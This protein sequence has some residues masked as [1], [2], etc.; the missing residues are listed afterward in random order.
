MLHLLNHIQAIRRDVYDSIQVTM[1]EISPR[2][3]EYQRQTLA[4]HA[5]KCAFL[6]CSAQDM[7]QYYSQPRGHREVFVLMME[8]L[9]NMVHDKVSWNDAGEMQQA[10]VEMNGDQMR[11][12]YQPLQDK[13]IRFFPENQLL[14]PTKPSGALSR[15]VDKYLRRTR[16]NAA[17]VPTGAYLTFRALSECVPNHRLIACDFDYLPQGSRVKGSLPADGTLD[18]YNAPLVSGESN[19]A[20]HKGEAVD[21]FT[22]LVPL[23]S[24]DIF[25]PTYFPMLKRMY[26]QV[27]KRELSK[28]EVIKSRE[29][30]AAHAPVKRAATRSGY[31]PL[32]E[33]FANTSFLLC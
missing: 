24:S 2:L 3:A 13:H 14:V 4:K 32:L 6:Q 12:V 8:V 30:L 10:S 31:N 1:V 17:F 33:D 20:N 29:F 5:D 15:F 25:F 21:H 9:D 27:C 28:V 11:E 7:S 19:V 26:S 23:G 16:H 18:A 22:Y